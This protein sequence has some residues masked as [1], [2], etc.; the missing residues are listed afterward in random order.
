MEDVLKAG[1]TNGIELLA[2][3][4][5]LDRTVGALLFVRD[6]AGRQQTWFFAPHHAGFCVDQFVRIFSK[7]GIGGQT[8]SISL[9]FFN[10]L[11]LLVLD[12]RCLSL[13]WKKNRD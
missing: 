1:Q 13:T 5:P 9:E 4:P 3:A 6:Q 10:T 2:F 8:S 11:M 7:W 12:K